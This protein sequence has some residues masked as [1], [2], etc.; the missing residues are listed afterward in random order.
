VDMATPGYG[1]PSLNA[2]INVRDSKDST[3]TTKI[4]TLNLPG[5]PTGQADRSFSGFKKM[6]DIMSANVPNLKKVRSEAV[7]GMQH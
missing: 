7:H 5:F 1:V 6:K 2:T 3:N 4:P